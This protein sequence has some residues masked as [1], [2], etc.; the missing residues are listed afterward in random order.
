MRVYLPAT[1][2][3][4]ARLLEHGAVGPVPL[5][6]FAVT[7]GLRE[8]YLDDDAEALEY[9]ALTE[10]ARASLRLIDA[11]PT[12]PRRRVVLAVDVADRAVT[13]R[14]DRDRGVVELADEVPM[15][16]VASAHVDDAA[17]ERTVAEAA[18]AVIAADLGDGGAQEL[19]D[20]A[21]GHELSWYAN[22]EIADLLVAL[23]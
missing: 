15:S 18:A 4:L 8:W 6:G 10:A 5:T 21:E 22:Q 17:A 11:D 2:G 19:V 16:S 3:V 20:D 13:I 9:A 12:T 1:T 7:P 23:R 14:D